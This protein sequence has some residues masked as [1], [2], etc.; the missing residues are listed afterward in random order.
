VLSRARGRGS[1]VIRRIGSGS[2]GVEPPRSGVLPA[3]ERVLG[4][5]DTHLH[6]GEALR[7]AFERA[8][9]DG[10]APLRIPSGSY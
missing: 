9:A 3:I 6:C 8:V 5:H 7:E 10:G 4:V 2:P 1:R